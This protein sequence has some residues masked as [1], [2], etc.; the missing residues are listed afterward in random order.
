MYISDFA[1]KM[2]N[3][4]SNIA[5]VGTFSDD[6]VDGLFLW[7]RENLQALLFGKDKLSGLSG[8]D[9]KQSPWAF[10][11][12]GLL[13][14][15]VVQGKRL[16]KPLIENTSRSAVISSMSGKLINYISNRELRCTCIREAIS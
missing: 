16:A 13:W 5:L 10:F 6:V 7:T 4:L 3:Q 1:S 14:G 12:Q 2:K 15:L 8:K 9:I 11:D